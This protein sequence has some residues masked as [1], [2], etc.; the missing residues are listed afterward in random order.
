[1][2]GR[3]LRLVACAAS[4]VLLAVPRSAIGQTAG[5]TTSAA[6][7][8]WTIA[9]FVGIARHSPVGSK[10]GVTPDRDHL[11]LG[12]HFATPVLRVGRVRLAY[13]PNLVPLVIV[14]NNPRYGADDVSGVVETGRA[15]V[16]GFGGS[17]VGLQASVPLSRRVAVHGAGAAGVLWFT[18]AIPIREARRFNLTLEWGGGLTV[19]SSSRRSVQV[20][21]KFHHLSNLYTAQENPGIDANVFYVSV[22]YAVRLPRE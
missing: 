22:Q 1:M 15:P 16:V 11:F 20:G 17:P 3:V 19:H 4:G 6:Y 18:D 12:V 8:T 9:P 7:G 5:S 13:A 14:T 21:Y 2:P 10:W